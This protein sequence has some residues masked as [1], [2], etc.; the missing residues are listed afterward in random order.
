MASLDGFRATHIVHAHE[1]RHP[2][3]WIRLSHTTPIQILFGRTVRRGGP[4]KE[5]R[6]T[7]FIV[8]L[9]LLCP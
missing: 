3:Y 6:H 8:S 1:D 2:C 9:R 4:A 7:V 5:C